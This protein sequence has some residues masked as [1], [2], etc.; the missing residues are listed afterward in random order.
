MLVTYFAGSP[1]TF[2]TAA[3]SQDPSGASLSAA[4]RGIAT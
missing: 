3:A 2:C 1:L 4:T